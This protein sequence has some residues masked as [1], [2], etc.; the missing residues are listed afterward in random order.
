MLKPCQVEAVHS[1]RPLQLRAGLGVD[2]LL[3]LQWDFEIISPLPLYK[4]SSFSE[5]PVIQP[6]CFL[7][8]F[9]ICYLSP[10]HTPFTHLKT[11][12]PI[13]LQPTSANIPCDI[14]INVEAWHRGLLA[15]WSSNL[16]RLLPSYPFQLPTPRPGQHLQLLYI[17]NVKFIH[18]TFWPPVYP[19]SYHSLYLLSSESCDPTFDLFTYS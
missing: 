9:T 19:S 13:P 2:I 16:Q 1:P 8:L 12:S 5:F 14:S 17:W 3:I 4:I 10:Q 15:L 7:L 6:Y 18:Q 11:Y